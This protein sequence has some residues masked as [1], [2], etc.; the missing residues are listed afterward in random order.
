MKAYRL[1]EEGQARE[2]AD[3]IR[4]LEWEQGKASTQKA[5]GTTKNNLELRTSPHLQTIRDALKEHALYSE[6]FISNIWPPKFNWYRD[7]GEYR[8]HSDAAFMDRVRTDLACTTFL[9]DDYDGGEL[10]I[11][12]QSIKGKPG[13]CVVYECWKPHWVNPSQS[14]VLEAANSVLLDT[15]SF[16]S[17]AETWF[18]TVRG[19]MNS[20]SAISV[21]VRPSVMRP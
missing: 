13:I 10:V 6:H 21:F 19:E 17:T 20:R 12:G 18:S 16:E 3:D 8:I 4:H 11:G 2:I 14:A 1:L 5:T 15:S 9:T 7:D